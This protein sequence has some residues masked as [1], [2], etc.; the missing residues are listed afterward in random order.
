VCARPRQRHHVGARNSSPSALDARLSKPATHPRSL[1]HHHRAA[2]VFPVFLFL[3]PG[4][5]PPACLLHLSLLPCF[6]CLTARPTPASRNSIYTRAPCCSP[7]HQTRTHGLSPPAIFQ[8][9]SS[10]SLSFTSHAASSNQN[11]P[12]A[13]SRPTQLRLHTP[14]PLAGSHGQS[15]PHLGAVLGSGGAQLRAGVRARAVP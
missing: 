14:A 2:R 3:S 1:P 13:G 6:L 5:P 15:R 12:D 9:C 8:S 10:L 4:T 11:P 7:T